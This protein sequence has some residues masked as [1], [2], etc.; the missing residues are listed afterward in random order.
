MR[1]SIALLLLGAAASSIETGIGREKLRGPRSQ[2]DEDSGED[3]GH[4]QKAK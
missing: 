2:S 1:T 4:A 3:D